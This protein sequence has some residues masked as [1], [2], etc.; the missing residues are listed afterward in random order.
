MNN[1]IISDILINE[2]IER[3]SLEKSFSSE[4]INAFIS[5]SMQAVQKA[6]KSQ[7]SRQFFVLNDIIASQALTFQTSSSENTA[8]AFQV[9]QI[10]ACAAIINEML[11]Q[12]EEKADVSN[13]KTVFQNYLLLFEII[14]SHKD[15]ITHKELAEEY[16][17]S[18]SSLSQLISKIRY[19]NFITYST[20]GREKYYFLTSKG[21]TILKSLR[22][23]MLKQQPFH[24]NSANR[25]FD[26]QKNISY[27]SMLANIQAS[28]EKVLN[29][30]SSEFYNDIDSQ[31]SISS[32]ASAITVNN[33]DKLKKSDIDFI[34]EV[35]KNQENDLKDYDIS[36]NK[37]AKNVIEQLQA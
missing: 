30:S 28:V 20:L 25:K 6:E 29:N 1:K 17:K 13:S 32:S 8:F 22:K 3:L 37:A 16:G 11:L 33:E 31:E 2:I 12:T 19:Y 21:K 15:G 14:D 24:N 4:Y 5:R 9:G 34:L 18:A 10:S 35:I 7:I 26:S 23:D 36:I 27:L